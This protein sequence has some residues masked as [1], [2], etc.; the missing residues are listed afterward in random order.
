[1]HYT[2]YIPLP[3]SSPAEAQTPA[4]LLAEVGCAHL[5]ADLQTP[6][7][8]SQGPD[9]AAGWLLHWMTSQGRVH[10]PQVDQ[11]IPA[12]ACDDLPAAR[13]WIG[14]DTHALP[15]PQDLQRRNLFA[16]SPVTL[17]DD[18]DWIIPR[19]TELPHQVRLLDD[20][21]KQF[22]PYRQFHEMHILSAQWRQALQAAVRGHRFIEKEL[23]SYVDHA[24][25]INYRTLPELTHNILGLYSTG[26]AGT[27]HSALKAA[28]AATDT[29]AEVI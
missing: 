8:T 22:I 24:L 28:V 15:T 11:W 20:G 16:G 1:M 14:V 4:E 13:Y 7:H 9:G 19:E 6:Q 27:I 29:T 25:Q 18:R 2:L 3:E 17:G 26:P 12:A 5:A 10:R 21:S 23:T